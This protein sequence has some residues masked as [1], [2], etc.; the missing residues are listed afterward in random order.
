MIDQ[1]NEAKIMITMK[2]RDKYVGYL[3][4]ADLVVDHLYLGAFTTIHKKVLTIKL[5]YGW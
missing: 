1:S 2:M 4:P 3:T 5:L